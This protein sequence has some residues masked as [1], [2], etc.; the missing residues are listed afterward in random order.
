MAKLVW[1]QYQFLAR[2][3][4]GRAVDF[5]PVYTYLNTTTASSMDYSFAVDYL[6]SMLHSLLYSYADIEAQYD[7]IS[8]IST[9]TLYNSLIKS[10]SY[11]LHAGVGDWQEGYFLPLVRVWLQAAFD[12][13]PSESS[14]GGGSS[15]DVVEF[16]DVLSTKLADALNPIIVRV[17]SASLEYEV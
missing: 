5:S 12:I 16:A 13:L 17:S 2:Y 7:A 10:V 15:F 3:F 14:S 1:D 11:I 8:S 6:A 4:I 9:S